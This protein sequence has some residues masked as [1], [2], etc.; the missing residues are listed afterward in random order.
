MYPF[1][2]LYGQICLA[3]LHVLYRYTMING[4]LI[5]HNPSTD[6]QDDG[7]YQCTAENSYGLILSN[8]VS[9]SFGCK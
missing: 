8:E 3:N 9:L 2:L 4:K 5:I 7:N 6:F 1:K